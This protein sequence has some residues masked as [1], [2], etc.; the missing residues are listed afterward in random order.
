MVVK[1]CCTSVFWRSVTMCGSS[2]GRRI[3]ASETNATS[4]GKKASGRVNQGSAGAGE[5]LEPHRGHRRCTSEHRVI[6]RINRLSGFY[7]FGALYVSVSKRN[8]G[9][10]GTDEPPSVTAERTVCA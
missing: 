8:G 6:P 2:S 1:D 5:I 9:N 3:P 4:L 7:P 10:T